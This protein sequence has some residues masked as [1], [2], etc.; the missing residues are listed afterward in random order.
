MSLD[1]AWHTGGNVTPAE[2]MTFRERRLVGVLVSMADT[3]VSDFD[4]V[5]LFHDLVVS[6]TDLLDVAAAGLLLAD[7]DGSLQVAAASSEAAHLVELL[8]LQN[9]GGPGSEAF[10]SVEPVHS[11]P[12]T[13]AQAEEKWPTFAKAA[14]ASGFKTATAVPMRLRRQVLGALTLFREEASGL[15]AEDLV[16]AQAL[17][18]LAT[19]AILQDRSAIDDRTV[20]HQLQTALDTRIVIEQAKGV[21]AQETGLGMDEAFARI[22]AYARDNN[23]RL[24]TVAQ[25]IASGD[26]DV[27]HLHAG[28]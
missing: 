13:E 17:A 6:G 19:I 7:E 5:D 14:Q 21:V 9:E 23:Q 2:L 18:D 8:E 1:D 16:I 3:L 15:S 28:S 11:G 22:R 24:R 12:L 25:Q 26:L 20:I 10:L 4:V 27:G